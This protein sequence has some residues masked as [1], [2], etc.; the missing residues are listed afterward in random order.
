MDNPRFKAIRNILTKYSLYKLA[1]N[2]F[3]NGELSQQQFTT[4]V[5]DLA[6]NKSKSFLSLPVCHHNF[7]EY[8]TE[9]YAKIKQIQNM[10][11]YSDIFCTYNYYR[12]RNHIIR[13]NTLTS[14]HYDIMIFLLL[15]NH[16]ELKVMG[17]KVVKV[18]KSK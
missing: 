17:F 18:E 5:R 9:L 12:L 13:D 6:K 2:R 1:L 16:K 7:G 8:F 4:Y 3:R 10:T 11:D 15:L 14:N